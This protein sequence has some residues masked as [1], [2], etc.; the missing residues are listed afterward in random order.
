MGRTKTSHN[1]LTSAASPILP[2][3]V[4]VLAAAEEASIGVVANVLAASSVGQTLINIYAHRDRHMYACTYMYTH[5]S[6][7]QNFQLQ[8]R[9]Q[10]Q[11]DVQSCQVQFPDSHGPMPTLALVWLETHT[12]AAIQDE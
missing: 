7:I 4:A 9:V 8:H 2:Q 10:L 6:T 1:R 12:H 3:L 11:L 5:R